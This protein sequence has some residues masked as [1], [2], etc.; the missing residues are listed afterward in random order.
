MLRRCS[1]ARRCCR[2]IVVV[3]W[4]KWAEPATIGGGSVLHRATLRCTHRR[5]NRTVI[6]R[7]IERTIAAGFANAARS[8][9]GGPC[10]AVGLIEW[11]HVAAIR[12]LRSTLICSHAVSEVIHL[13]RADS[14]T[15]AHVAVT[16]RRKVTSTR[17]NRAH[18]VLLHGLTQTRLLMLERYRPRHRAA[19]R[20]EE[21]LRPT[22]AD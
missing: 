18:A 9:P 20:S 10:I 5:R 11:P 2:A 4:R 12:V 22:I 13:P 17:R 7:S 3:G 8:L 16:P 21:A 6:I 1:H 19:R 14:S 15:G